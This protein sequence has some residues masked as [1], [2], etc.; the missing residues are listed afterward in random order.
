MLILLQCP[1]EVNQIP[2][3]RLVIVHLPLSAKL[4][5][6]RKNELSCLFG[7]LLYKSILVDVNYM[8]VLKFLIIKSP[9]QYFCLFAGFFLRLVL[10]WCIQIV[11]WIIMVYLYNC[12]KGN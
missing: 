6:S 12:F 9:C 4:V 1:L 11:I 10:D 3:K 8:S 2:F 5:I 7:A